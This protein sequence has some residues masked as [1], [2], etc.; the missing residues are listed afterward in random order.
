LSGNLDKFSAF[1]ALLSGGKKLPAVVKI[2]ANL[3]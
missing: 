2:I 1:K 3:I